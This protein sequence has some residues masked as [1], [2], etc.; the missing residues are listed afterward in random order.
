MKKQ[1]LSILVGLAIMNGCAVNRNGTYSKKKYKTKS[2]KIIVTGTVY[3]TDINNRT[4]PGVAI[5][6]PNNTILTKTGTDGKFKFEVQKGS[7]TFSASWIGYLIPSTKPIKLVEG[8]SIVIDFVL[9]EAL[10]ETIN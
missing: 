8:D 5:K 10:L 1:V 9:K 3:D 4:L 7:H 2:N 6:F